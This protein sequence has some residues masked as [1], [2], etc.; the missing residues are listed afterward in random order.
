MVNFKCYCGL[1]YNYFTVNCSELRVHSRRQGVIRRTLF[2]VLLFHPPR[3][4]QDPDLPAPQVL[5][6]SCLPEVGFS[7]RHGNRLVA[8]VE[9]SARRQDRWN[10]TSRRL[11]RQTGRQRQRQQRSSITAN[12]NNSNSN[13]S[14]I[15]KS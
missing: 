1:K 7:R 11:I 6:R 2:A 13:I 15:S 10:C 3:L 8:S 12:T 9:K 4:A 14:S 5:S